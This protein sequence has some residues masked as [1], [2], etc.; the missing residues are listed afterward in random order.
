MKPILD[1]QKAEIVNIFDELTLWSSPFG[2]L[3]LD[4]IPMS[5]EATVLDLGFGT[6]FPLIEL[7]QRF[8]ISSK[9]YGMDIWEQGIVKAKE[10]IEVLG[11]SQIEI[12]A[13]SASNIP[14]P[15]NNIDLVTSNLGINNFEDKGKVYAEV[16]RVL[17]KGGSLCLTTN[18]KGTF[19]TLFRI[20]EDV[21]SKMGLINELNTFQNYLDHRG[22]FDT[23]KNEIIP[24]GF[25]LVNTVSDV[26]KFRFVD[27]DAVFNHV[28]IRVGFRSYWENMISDSLRQEFFTEV[29]TGIQDII[30][31]K[32]EFEL[33][34]PML[35]LEFRKS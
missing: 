10:R 31:V 2:R 29:A 13:Q 8:G 32:G 6:G 28:L 19:A 15:N 5:S 21:F 27:V 33:E 4:H 9:I 17:K 18:V 1:Y 35:Y 12:F 14:L 24:H 22:N 23:I 7:A 11:L 16:Y 20:F 30:M 26:S 25:E 3:L 34:V